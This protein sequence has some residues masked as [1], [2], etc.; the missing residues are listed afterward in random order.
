[1]YAT[2]KRDRFS[3]TNGRGQGKSVTS[4]GSFL[5]DIGMF[6]ATEFGMAPKDARAVAVAARKLVEV[7]FLALLDSGIE[8]RGR[9]VG[10]YASATADDIEDACDVVSTLLLIAL[11]ARDDPNKHLLIARDGER[12]FSRRHSMHG[13]QQDFVPPRPAGSVHPSRHRLQLHRHRRSSSS[14]VSPCRRVRVSCCRRL[15]AQFAV[16]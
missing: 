1:M 10:C 15:S 13:C 7:S 12:R 6:D 8:Y 2:D 3:W 9:N 4:K 5:K 16:R 14:S 11:S